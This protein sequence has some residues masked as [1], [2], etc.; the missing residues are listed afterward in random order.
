MIASFQPDK[1]GNPGRS[2][3]SKKGL[4]DDP[5]THDAFNSPLLELKQHCGIKWQ[6]YDL[7]T[8]ARLDGEKSE[9]LSFL[10]LKNKLCGVLSLF[11]KIYFSSAHKIALVRETVL[12]KEAKN[13]GA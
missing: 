6:K 5:H 4:T 11:K 13:R 1:K 9:P 8:E 3:Q 12:Q 7:K 2:Y 10:K